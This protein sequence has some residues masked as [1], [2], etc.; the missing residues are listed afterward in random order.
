SFEKYDPP[1]SIDITNILGQT[2]PQPS[3]GALVFEID[4]K[5][6]R[7]DA[8]DEGGDEYF[9]IYGDQTNE[10]ET[11]PSGRYMY[12]H[13]PDENGKVIVDFNK[14]YN[15]PCAFTAFATCPLPPKQNVLDVA[16]TSGERNFGNH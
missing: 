15:P 16:I 11:Y 9:V 2:Y 8:I 3:P 1:K 13:P 5:E 14:G 10:H 6:F 4:G 12:V 7:L